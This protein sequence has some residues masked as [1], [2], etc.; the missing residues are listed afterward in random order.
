M[1]VVLQRAQILATSNVVD[2]DECQTTC[3]KSENKECENTIGSYECRCV[4]GYEENSTTNACEG[5]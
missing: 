5:K 2:V 3:L 1:Y 4:R